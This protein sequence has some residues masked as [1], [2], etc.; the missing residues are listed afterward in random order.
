MIPGHPLNFGETVMVT[1]AKKK[2]KNE[3]PTNVSRSALWT[4]AHEIAGIN[5]EI[6]RG[7]EVYTLYKKL[8]EAH[9]ELGH[10]LVP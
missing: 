4:V 1:H 10:K 9:E 8:V 2:H 5:T 7:I 3:E 6:G